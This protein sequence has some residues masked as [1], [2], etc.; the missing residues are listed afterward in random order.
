M[1]IQPFLAMTKAPRL[2]KFI[3]DSSGKEIET[4]YKNACLTKGELRE[5]NKALFAAVGSMVGQGLAHQVGFQPRAFQ[6]LLH[7]SHSV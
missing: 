3:W 2:Y 1:T 7:E 5:I 6:P 4:I